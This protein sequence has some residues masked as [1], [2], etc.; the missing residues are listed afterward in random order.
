[1]LSVSEVKTNRPNTFDVPLQKLVYKM[2]RE[3]GVTYQR[4]ETNVTPAVQ[5]YPLLEAALQVKMMQTLLL[6]D[7]Q[8]NDFYLVITPQEKPFTPEDLSA[9]LRLSP[10]TMAPVKLLQSLLGTDTAGAT[11]LSLLLD[12]EKHVQLVIDR[13]VIQAEYFGCTDGSSTNFLKLSTEWLTGE[14]IPGM[15]HDPLYVNF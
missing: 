9:E 15:G 13:E 1:M 11:I 14:F 10:V 6:C 5:E 8:Q 7:R 4:V 2:L 3:K 12:T